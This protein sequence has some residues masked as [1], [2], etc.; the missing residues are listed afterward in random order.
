M[1]RIVSIILC[2]TLF[3]AAIPLSAFAMDDGIV[4]SGNC[5]KNGDNLKWTLYDSGELVISGEGEMD[6][7]YVEKESSPM[8]KQPWYD[9]FDEIQ[10]VTVE[11]GV[12]SIGAYAFRAE[13]GRNNSLPLSKISLPKSIEM[14]EENVAAFSSSGIFLRRALCYAG[15]ETKWNTVHWPDC[16]FY[17]SVNTE[18]G[19]EKEEWRR[20]L[21]LGYIG[22]DEFKKAGWLEYFNG[23]EP[24]PFVNF[25][26]EEHI[27]S[28][29]NKT[30]TVSAYY[31]L[32][33]YKDAKLVWS[34]EGDSSIVKETKNSRGIT[35][36]V[37]ISTFER[38]NA[39][40]KVE[41]VSADGSVIASD[42]T[43]I[44]SAKIA[45][46]DSF[47]KAMEKIGNAFL[48][49][50]SAMIL[51]IVYMPMMIWAGMLYIEAQLTDFFEKIF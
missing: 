38:G 34:I 40:L 47:P 20:E 42:T 2:F 27:C 3:A 29:D 35:S 33:E 48:A 28:E 10:F 4:D 36:G 51:G 50:Y 26:K 23:E 49:A 16:K 25:G 22:N 13:S 46:G 17:R 19:V 7:W 9:Y 32:D 44:T 39:T 12:T 21:W 41:M 37:E 31:Y 8:K 30:I 24:E 6:W 14:I 45:K 43:K 1:K 18:N 11:E 5:G 15:E